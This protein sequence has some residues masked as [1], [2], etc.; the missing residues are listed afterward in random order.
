MF[1]DFSRVDPR[2]EV[3]KTLPA[4]PITPVDYPLGF[5]PAPRRRSSQMMIA[6]AQYRS[7]D[8]AEYQ[9]QFQQPNIRFPSESNSSYHNV[10]HQKY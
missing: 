4:P 3:P 7:A 1:R 10:Y 9:Y 5:K 2:Y 8:N 6:M